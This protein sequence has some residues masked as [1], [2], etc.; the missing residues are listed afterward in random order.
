MQQKLQ[1]SADNPGASGRGPSTAAGSA[2]GAALNSQD[3][4]L[5]F[6]LK[7]VGLLDDAQVGTVQSEAEERKISVW[8][9]LR[10]KNW[11]SEETIQEHLANYLHLPAIALSEIELDREAVKLLKPTLA[12]EF[13]CVP[14]RREVSA[15]H[16]RRP[17]L[18]VAM[19]NPADV[20]ALE[21]LEFATG[22]AIK[23][24][25]AKRGEILEALEKSQ[26][27]ENWLGDVMEGLSPIEEEHSPFKEAEP[28]ELT[29]EEQAPVIRMA[30]MA[31]QEAVRQAAS[32]I[33]IE[34][35]FNSVRIRI[36]VDGILRELLEAPKWVQ[37]SLISR[38]KIMAKLDITER[39]IPQ[40]GRIRLRIKEEAIDLRVSTMPSQFGEKMVLRLLGEDRKVPSLSVI[41]L[42][43]RDLESLRQAVAQPQ[44]M[45]L[46]T[47]PTGSGK[48]T[49]LYSLLKAIKDPEINIITV[50]DPIE[51]QTPG[52]TQVQVNVKAGLTFASCVRSILRQDP[53][54]ILVGEIRD[55]ETAEIAFQA[56]NT[57]HLTLSTVHSNSTTATL[58]RLLDLGCD[59]ALV[60]NS[61][62]LILAQRL[63]RKICQYCKEPY[64]PDPDMLARLHLSAQGEPFYRG[65]GCGRC[66]QRGYSGRVGIFEMLRMTTSIRE[67]IRKRATEGELRNAASSLGTV[68][69]LEDALAKV[70]QGITTLDEVI[71]VVYLEEDEQSATPEALEAITINRASADLIAFPDRATAAAPPPRSA[72]PMLP[73]RIPAME[74][75]PISIASAAPVGVVSPEWLA[76][77]SRVGPLPRDSAEANDEIELKPGS[78]RQPD[79]SCSGCG[80]NLSP[81]WRCCPYC[82]TPVMATAIKP[83]K[84]EE[85]ALDAARIAPTSL[86]EPDLF[87]KLWPIRMQT[88]APSKIPQG[89]ER[90]FWLDSPAQP[91]GEPGAAINPFANGRPGPAPE[92]D[93][94]TFANPA[95]QRWNAMSAPDQEKEAPAAQ[96]ALPRLNHLP[97]HEPISFEAPAF[98]HFKPASPVQFEPASPAAYEAPEPVP[99]PFQSASPAPCEAPAPES[100]RSASPAQFEAPAPAQFEAPAPFQSASPAPYEAPAPESFRSASP[101]PCEAPAPE[102]FRSASPAQFEAPAPA[103]FEAS[104]PFRSASPAPCEAPAPESFMSA[105]PAQFEA[106]APAQFEAPAPYQSASPAPCEAPAP[107]S[108][109]SASPAQFEAPAPAQFEASAPAQFEAPAP[110][111]FEADSIS[112]FQPASPA[113]VEAESYAPAGIAS[114]AEVA[115]SL[116][117]PMHK[118]SPEAPIAS[119]AGQTLH[120]V[121]ENETAKLADSPKP[122]PSPH[123]AIPPASKPAPPPSQKKTLKSINLLLST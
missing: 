51:V 69:L 108:F 35:T 49:T 11:A 29:S 96:L 62:N 97:R 33:H 72:E 80:E 86:P 78:R 53:D 34:P 71:R 83:A 30:N 120:P 106:P 2:S 13:L 82:E 119:P 121:R 107:E 114:P 75:A 14:L 46:V 27:P 45:I 21:Y 12:R 18:V 117:N 76:E 28:S 84:E 59:P 61:L 73:V 40:D 63:V 1:I 89:Q 48:T 57:G 54:V 8:Q 41:G 100:F 44:G 52:I 66:G 10:E 17:T 65:R 101:A 58:A 81:R 26:I 68:F 37:D 102:S 31:L 87:N 118:A 39:R 92:P 47:G 20:S 23:P 104:A 7:R 43:P 19:A 95:L 112:Q 115:Y 111:Q 56:S 77:S 93:L 94:E 105:S 109:R 123:S 90:E 38:L 99:S 5:C 4:F 25:V 79:L 22:H 3:R 36:R 98:Q 60:G 50:E 42:A 113:P 70:R 64:E 85:L 74:T 116:V 16:M 15:G 122:A 6:M 55:L 9:L 91:L 110:A 67:L 103:Q 32:D 24:V 88:A